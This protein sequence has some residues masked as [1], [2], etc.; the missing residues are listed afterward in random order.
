MYLESKRLIHRDLA[1]RNILGMGGQSSLAKPTDIGGSRIFFGG[2]GGV[3]WVT[4]VEA[5]ILSGNRA[6]R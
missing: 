3:G 6:F 1:A 2:G 5:H 4:A